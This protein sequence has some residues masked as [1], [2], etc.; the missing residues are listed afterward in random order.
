MTIIFSNYWGWTYPI[1]L[2]IIIFFLADIAANK[3]RI[4]SAVFNF[5]GNAVGGAA[6]FT[7]C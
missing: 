2:S 7:P 4:T 1:V 3:A 6:N 5:I